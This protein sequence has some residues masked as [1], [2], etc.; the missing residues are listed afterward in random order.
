MDRN[1]T[2][3]P[4][5]ADVFR[6]EL[7]DNWE[8]TVIYVMIY[9]QFLFSAVYALSPRTIGPRSGYMPERLARLVPAPENGTKIPFVRG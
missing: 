2:K 1:T 5:R 3:K 8:S 9:S 6:W 7:S 4:P